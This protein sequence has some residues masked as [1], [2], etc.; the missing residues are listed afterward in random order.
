MDT[1]DLSLLPDN[2]RGLIEDWLTN[3][4]DDNLDED[5]FAYFLDEHITREELEAF[6]SPFP[7]A[8]ELV[9]RVLSLQPDRIVNAPQDEAVLLAALRE[10]VAEMARNATTVGADDLAV[11]AGSL[12][13]FR[14]VEEITLPRTEFLEANV[15]EAVFDAISEDLR[16]RDWAVRNLSHITSQWFGY[17]WEHAYVLQP[18]LSIDLDLRA[19]HTLW[20][21]GGEP[22]VT[23]DEALVAS[24]IKAPRAVKPITLANL[25]DGATKEAA[26]E[27]MNWSELPTEGIDVANLQTAAAEGDYPALAKLSLMYMSGIGVEQDTAG[28]FEFMER[29]AG[30]YPSLLACYETGA[31]NNVAAAHYGLYYMCGQGCGMVA[32]KDVAAGHL[33]RA[34]DG[35]FPRAMYVLGLNLGN[36]DK[37]SDED[38]LRRAGWLQKAADAGMPEAYGQLYNLYKNNDLGGTA[39]AFDALL[40]AADADGFSNYQFQLAGAYETGEGTA[41]NTVA[42]LKWYYL[43]A[44][45]TG[46]KWQ[47]LRA[48][49]DQILTGTPRPEVELAREQ[50]I[51]WLEARSAS[52]E[53]FGFKDDVFQDPFTLLGW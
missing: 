47:K 34:A 30:D 5:R 2:R 26:R 49:L 35:G 13:Q 15:K 53:S 20:V 14:L 32:S 29:A 10:H 36:Y 21:L 4:R 50:A 28:A 19:F 44:C 45:Q 1:P 51:E 16:S 42:A 46:V 11:A 18:L 6:M 23:S 38:L 27:K 40:R 12:R 24:F 9:E 17:G 8:A 7:C 39:K 48:A 33:Q 43:T 3:C 25:Q 52:S 22:F 37:A 41:Q 31:S